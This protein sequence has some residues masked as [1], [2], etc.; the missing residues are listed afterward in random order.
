MCSTD[1]QNSM[2]LPVIFSQTCQRQRSLR[3]GGTLHNGLVRNSRTQGRYAEVEPLFRLALVIAEK[4]PGPQHPNVAKTLA[5]YG[6]LLR[7]T[8]REAEAARMK[9]RAK[10]IR[11]KHKQLEVLR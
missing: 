3:A 2:Y 8:N 1:F 9:A 11:T 7:K 4:A 10:A 5:D 6:D